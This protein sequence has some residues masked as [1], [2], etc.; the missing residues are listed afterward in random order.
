[1]AQR[2]KN[3]EPR[4]QPRLYLVTPPLSDAAGFVPAL[5][6]ALAAGDVCAV[7]VRVAEA[8]ERSSINRIKALAPAVQEA[9]AALLIDGHPNQVARA[10]AAGAPATGLDEIAEP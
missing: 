6:E 1:M 2:P 8:D 5:A 4:P 9:G 7:L 3:P 10:G